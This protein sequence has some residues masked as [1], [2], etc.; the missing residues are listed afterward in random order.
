MVDDLST[1]INAG[2]PAPTHVSYIAKKGVIP[3]VCGWICEYYNKVKGVYLED[4]EGG[5]DSVK[6]GTSRWRVGKFPF[7]RKNNIWIK[8][9]SRQSKPTDY[10]EDFNEDDFGD[11]VNSDRDGQMTS[12]GT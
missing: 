2:V 5:D 1:M 4:S 8:N 12:E 7:S 9:L 11:D 10:L 3:S 6:V